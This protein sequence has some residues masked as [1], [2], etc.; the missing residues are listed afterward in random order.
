MR[1]RVWLFVVATLVGGGIGYAWNWPGFG[2]AYKGFLALF[3][4]AEAPLSSAAAAIVIAFLMGVPRICV[5]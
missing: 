1:A 3:M 2:R 4:D 5:P